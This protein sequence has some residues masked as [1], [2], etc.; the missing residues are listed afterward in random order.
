VPKVAPGR[1]ATERTDS[2]SAP[3]RLSIL[4][5]LPAS[6][7]D[8]REGDEGRARFAQGSA[9]GRLSETLLCS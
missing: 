2:R 9:Q 1:R 3:Y 8:T 5:D 6:T 4:G 7:A